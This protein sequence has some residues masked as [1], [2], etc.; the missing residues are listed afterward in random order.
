MKTWIGLT[1]ITIVGIS[2]VFGTL[3]GIYV[4]SWKANIEDT[5][6]RVAH[7][8]LQYVEEVIQGHLRTTIFAARFVPINVAPN[9]LLDYY[10]QYHQSSGYNI[11]SLGYL[12]RAPNTTNGKW[13][14]QVA[15]FKPVCPIYG[16]YFSNATIYPQFHGYCAN[17]NAIDFGTLA[18]NDFDY[19]L[20]PQEEQ[21][22]N[23]EITETFLPKFE[24]LGAPTLTYEVKRDDYVSFADINV[25]SLSKFIAE[26]ITFVKGGSIWIVDNLSGEVLAQSS[27]IISGGYVQTFHTQY[28]GLEWTTYVAKQNIY[29]DMDNRII[30][31]CVVSLVFTIAVA[32][33]IYL[34]TYHWIVK[35][36]KTKES[37]TPFDDL[38]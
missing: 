37:F 1:L 8:T 25:N 11:S 27:P 33:A 5:W 12:T 3:T 2:I 19:G 6:N 24:L 38:E 7:E 34:M 32:I 30:I 10:T 14:W 23:N 22:L 29:S 4:S 20:K 18:Y 21:L 15:E 9:A 36:L 26:N 35:P 13:S 28:P 17:T 31:A 16:Y